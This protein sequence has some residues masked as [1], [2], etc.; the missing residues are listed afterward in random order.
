MNMV[1]VVWRQVTGTLTIEWR[2]MFYDLTGKHG[3]GSHCPVCGCGRLRTID[4]TDEGCWAQKHAACE[5][6][7]TE[8]WFQFYV[9]S[10]LTR[11]EEE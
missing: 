8:M 5:D 1:P 7:G 11:D 10:V 4:F 3:D 2:E 9:G 6:C